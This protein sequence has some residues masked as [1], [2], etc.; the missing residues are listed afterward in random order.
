MSA[1]FTHLPGF[2]PSTGAWPPA[3]KAALD[4]DYAPRN[5]EIA[6]ATSTAAF[7]FPNDATTVWR[8]VPALAI[9]VAVED[10]PVLVEAWLGMAEAGAMGSG[11]SS[12]FDVRILDATNNRTLA[13][14]RR[15]V[16]DWWDESVVGLLACRL[17]A[18]TGTVAARVQARSVYNSNSSASTTTLNPA[19]MANTLHLVARPV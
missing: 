9:T 14:L 1:P 15:R 11:E 4:R 16:M 7:T 2:D 6:A 10:T 19:D 8:D 17:P 13:F 12:I 3:T 5:A 18:G